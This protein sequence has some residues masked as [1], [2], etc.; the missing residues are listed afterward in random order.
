M[1]AHV[2]THERAERPPMDRA[3]LVLLAAVVVTGGAC[4]W[5]TASVPSADRAVVA[6]C[7]GVAALALCAA[8]A[9]AAYGFQTA[10]LLR[11]RIATMESDLGRLADQTLPAVVKRLR[12]GASS[13]TAMSAVEQPTDAI[14]RRILRTLV[15]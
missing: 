6:A 9:L 13:D 8:L 4:L 1:S 7:T 2:P 11:D 3:L 12:D 10:R 5:A 14:H 15:D